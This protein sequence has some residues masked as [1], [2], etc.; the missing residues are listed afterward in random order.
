MLLLETVVCLLISTDL[1]FFAAQR[2]QLHHQFFRYA[3]GSLDWNL[4]RR[5]LRSERRWFRWHFKFSFF[6]AFSFQLSIKCS[7][8]CDHNPIH[9]VC[10]FFISKLKLTTLHG[11]ANITT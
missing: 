3:N 10:Q 8:D 7:D 2:I 11:W 6:S 5:L 9:V 1:P 4:F